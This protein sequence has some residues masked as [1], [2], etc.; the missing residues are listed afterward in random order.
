M[1][2]ENET[3]EEATTGEPDAEGRDQA[4]DVVEELKEHEDELDE[5][6]EEASGEPAAPQDGTE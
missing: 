2:E 6:S 3:Q 1:S 5:G 4:E